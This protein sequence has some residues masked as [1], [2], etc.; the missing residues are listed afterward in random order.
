MRGEEKWKNS[1]SNL[2]P[3]SRNLNGKSLWDVT[4]KLLHFLGTNLVLIEPCV[5]PQLQ[6]LWLRPYEVSSGWHAAVCVGVRYHQALKCFSCRRSETNFTDS[7]KPTT[8]W[9]HLHRQQVEYT[10]NLSR[11][12]RAHT[13]HTPRVCM[14]TILFPVM[15]DTGSVNLSLL[16]FCLINI[17]AFLICY[18]KTGDTESSEGSVSSCQRTPIY[19]PFTQCRPPIDYPPHPAPHSVTEE[20]LHFVKTCLQRWRTEVENDINGMSMLTVTMQH[21]QE[22][23]S[24]VVMLLEL[25]VFTSWLLT[26]LTV[27]QC[28]AG[29]THWLH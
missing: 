12:R 18:S 6:K 2:Q 24:Y 23:V 22:Q 27:T 9:T 25:T 4:Q 19:K 1:R 26:S 8:Q 10:E 28:W 14:L 20:E 7:Y 13:S 15:L 5:S 29:S 17:D 21:T 3:F 16:P 11:N